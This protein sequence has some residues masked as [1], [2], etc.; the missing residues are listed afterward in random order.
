MLKKEVA[1]IVMWSFMFVCSVVPAQDITFARDPCE[2]HSTYMKP[3]I[4]IMFNEILVRHE[5][6]LIAIGA[7][8][9]ITVPM[10]F[11]ETID[12]KLHAFLQAHL[13]RNENVTC[14]TNRI[15]LLNKEGA[16]N[17]VLSCY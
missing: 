6:A 14:Y 8:C 15:G 11:S 2:I 10:G 16:V 7:D 4:H 1:R 3:E 9:Y 13:L 5:A 12:G 17:H